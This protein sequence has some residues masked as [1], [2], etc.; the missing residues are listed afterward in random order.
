MTTSTEQTR[1]PMRD[2]APGDRLRDY[3][4]G[5][6]VVEAVASTAIRVL[7]ANHRGTGKPLRETF[8]LDHW[9]LHWE[10]ARLR[11][12]SNAVGVVLEVAGA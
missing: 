2:P 10:G 8:R 9:R 12:G 6:C 3:Y 7:W 1:D 4:F 5:E 11:V